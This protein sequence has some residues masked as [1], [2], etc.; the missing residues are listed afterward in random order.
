MALLNYTTTISPEK[1]IN[2]I[3][4]TLAKSG[5]SAIMSEYDDT[6]NIVA[7][8]F[9]LKMDDQFISFK[10][11]TDW[12]PVQAVLTEQRRRNSRIKTDEA[13]A[14]RVAWRITKDWVE[15]QL[16]IIETRMVTTAQVFL[17]YAVTQ[18][19]QTMYEHVASN[20]SLLLTTGTSQ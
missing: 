9:R 13:Q 5:A 14:R 11:P 4:S 2:E 18:N 8:S 12:K 10:L 19:G 3:Q 15:A 7:L 16:A 20:T 17:P 6:G 1:S